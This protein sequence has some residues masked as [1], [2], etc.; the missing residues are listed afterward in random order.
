MRREAPILEFDP[1][2][3]AVIEPSRYNRRIDVAEHCVVTFFQDVID[4]LAAQQRLR[5]VKS[6]RSEIGLHPLYEI[7][8]DGRRLALI[9]PG[10]GA[11]LAAA[12][13]ESVIARGC[14]KFVVCGGAGVLDSAI[15]AG[16]AIVLS[17]AVRD[18]GTSY[19]YLPPGRVVEASPEATAALE[20]VLRERGQPCRT[21]L[22]W[23]TDA[24]FRETRDKVRARR[25]EGCAVVEM[26]A[27][28]L[29]A[30]ARFRGVTIGQVVYGGDDV[31]GD[32]HDHR[33]WLRLERERERLFAAAAEACLRL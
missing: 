20:A 3:A 25:E 4:G 33:D 1:A 18:E 9:H 14:R 31:S 12:L 13:L 5:M 29:F 21:A 22:S 10:V 16:Q 11:P 28:A 6:I 27:A 26:E 7:S 17:G 19:H 2:P 32:E 30:V 24:I 15:A 23:T 8:L